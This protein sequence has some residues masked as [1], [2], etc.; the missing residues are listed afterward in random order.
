ML[1]DRESPPAVVTIALLVALFLGTSPLAV[2]SVVETVD[3]EGQRAVSTTPSPAD[4]GGP[5]FP[6]MTATVQNETA[7]PTPSETLTP[8]A[9]PTST[10][11]ATSTRTPTPTGSSTLTSTST[12]TPTPRQT[13]TSTSTPTP[14]AQEPTSQ[15]ATRVDAPP[16]IVVTNLTVPE[17]VRAGE[18]YTVLTTVSNPARETR[19]ERIEYVFAD[20]TVASRVVTLAGGESRTLRFEQRATDQLIDSQS[21]TT[22]SYV[23]GVRNASGEG[24][25][26]YLRVSP[27]VDFSIDGFQAPATAPIDRQFVVLANVSNPAE[28][29]VTRDVRYRFAGTI[30][31]EKTVTVGGGE[32][33]QVAFAV[34]ADQLEAADAAVSP[35][36]TYNHRIVT[37]GGVSADD[38]IRLRSGSGVSADSLAPQESTFPTDLR[39]GEEYTVSLT[40]RNVETAAFSGQ[41]VYRVDGSVVETKSIELSS[42]QQRTI[43]FDVASDDVEQM[44]SP[45]SSRTVTQSV[46]IGNTSLA[47]REL[48]VSEANTDTRT[49]TPRQSPTFDDAGEATSRDSAACQRGFFSRCG[50]TSFDQTTLTIIGTVSSVVGILYEMLSGGS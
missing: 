30:V 25:P 48:R 37:A 8:T 24:A 9:T 41:F 35:D 17:R 45:L 49:S 19:L 6:Q 15:P 46:T 4:Y 13:P 23:H 20:S 22:G 47:S 28:M 2:A 5:P 16:G 14:T 26:R 34:T 40:V 31:A 11:T 21:L 1:P 42:G 29:T 7:T 33:K 38:A 12:A 3:D 43:T 44:T 10:P 36:R 32:Q 27:A 39:A 50:T 18:T